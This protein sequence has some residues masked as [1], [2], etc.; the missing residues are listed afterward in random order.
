MSKIS[1]I[2]WRLKNKKKAMFYIAKENNIPTTLFKVRIKITKKIRSWKIK[3]VHSMKKQAF[4]RKS[5][6]TPNL[7]ASR[8]T[9][10]PLKTKRSPK[11][12]FLLEAEGNL[13][14]GQNE[15][16]LVRKL[17]RNSSGLWLIDFSRKKF[18]IQKRTWPFLCP[19]GNE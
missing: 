15:N 7:R 9:C 4:R 2:R 8:S 16:W 12:F 11:N 13:A 17:N 1:V 14:P 3:K 19:R 18:T 6:Q 10:L 5:K